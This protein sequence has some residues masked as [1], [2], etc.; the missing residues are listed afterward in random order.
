MVAYLDDS[1][2]EFTGLLAGAG[3]WDNTLLFFSTDNGECPQGAQ[4]TAPTKGAGC[5]WP[6]RAS[7]A[8]VFEGGVCG[9]P[10]G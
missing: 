8:S 10:R 9:P 2:A 1:V 3:M 6:L 7:K 5:N 4:C